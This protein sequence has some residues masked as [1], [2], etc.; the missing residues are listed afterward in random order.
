M[1]RF[2]EVKNVF[3]Q[4]DTVED[5]EKSSEAEFALKGID[6]EIDKGEFVAIVGHNGS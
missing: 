2:I 6:L 4:Y 3:F 1:E 5:E